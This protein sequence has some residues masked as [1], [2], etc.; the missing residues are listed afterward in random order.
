MHNGQIGNWNL[1]RRQVEGM[2]PDSLYGSRLGTTDSE[3][4]FLAILG[5]VAAGVARASLL[6][7][8]LRVTFW[9]AIA[10]AITAA[11][12]SLFGVAA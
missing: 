10:M 2:I 4:V 9:G 7:G 6:K 11:V 5:A 8:C 3:A 12:G 1:I